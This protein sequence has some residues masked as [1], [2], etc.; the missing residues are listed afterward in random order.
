[1]LHQRGEIIQH[2]ELL[3]YQHA[4]GQQVDVRLHA[5]NRVQHEGH[6]L[7]QQ[8]QVDQLQGLAVLEGPHEEDPEALLILVALLPQLPL[9]PAATD[10]ALHEVGL[11][12]CHVVVPLLIIVDH[13]EAEGHLRLLHQDADG[14]LVDLLVPQRAHG[15]AV[16]T[17]DVRHLGVGGHAGLELH[18]PRQLQQMVDQSQPLQREDRLLADAAHALPARLFAH[19]HRAVLL[20]MEGRGVLARGVRHAA[21]AAAA[22]AGRSS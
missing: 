8:R 19:L 21:L 12:V 6:M 9:V 2:D 20:L 14:I 4:A 10:H 15:L 7:D 16:A 18:Q 1:M 13:P 11:P 22:A 5:Q 3:P 17:L